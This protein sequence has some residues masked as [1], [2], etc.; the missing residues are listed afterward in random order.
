MKREFGQFQRFRVIINGISFFT[1]R[2][3]VVNGV[4]D[5]TKVNDAVKAAIKELERIREQ[6]P[7]VGVCGTWCG[8]DVQ[9]SMI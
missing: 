1:S 2:A 9:L 5:F 6:D 8:F 3:A 7:A 4:G